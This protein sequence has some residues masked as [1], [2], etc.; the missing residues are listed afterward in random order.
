MEKQASFGANLPLKS[1]GYAKLA[2]NISTEK[3][4]RKDFDYYY[5]LLCLIEIKYNKSLKIIRYQK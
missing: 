3:N 4:K 2:Q 1:R 5:L